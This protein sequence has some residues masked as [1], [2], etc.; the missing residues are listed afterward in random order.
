MRPFHERMYETLVKDAFDLAGLTKVASFDFN[1][2]LANVV[3]TQTTFAA[4]LF[5]FVRWCRRYG[6]LGEFVA[7]A[8]IE[9]PDRL[10][11]QALKR[12][13]DQTQPDQPAG[14]GELTRFARLFAAHRS[15]FKYLQAY[16]NLHDILHLLDGARRDLEPQQ[17]ARATAGT[18]LPTITINILKEWVRK[19]TEWDKKADPASPNPWVNEFAT[20]VGDLLGPDDKQKLLHVT[21][22]SG[23]LNLPAKQ[24][25]VLNSKL[26]SAAHR[27]ELADMADLLDVRLDALP[28]LAEA[29]TEFR[30]ICVHFGSLIT[31]HTLCQQIDTEVRLA[32]SLSPKTTYEWPR[33]KRVSKWLEELAAIRH[34]D[35]SGNEV[36]A[37]SA[38]FSAGGGVM[39][40]D[41]FA[42]TFAQW[43]LGMDK[44]L[45]DAITP[46]L[47]AAGDL[48]DFLR[49]PK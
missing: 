26:V 7:A 48:S 39:A 13:F 3:W 10:D 8:A 15:G 37:A 46:L 21:A 29:V 49:D 31:A 34:D 20:D 23:I 36:R 40:F 42:D 30:K 5:E 14:V 44:E 22:L 16:K 4:V 27:L 38:R 2:T 28:L 41:G 45:L 25:A 1:V 43:F 47:V 32:E 17:A 24:L 12:E 35:P 19:S 33:W 18:P 6:R 11:V 9:F